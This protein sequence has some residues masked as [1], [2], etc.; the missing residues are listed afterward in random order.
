MAA[1]SEPMQKQP[2]KDSDS[3]GVDTN[4]ITAVV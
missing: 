4:I 3:G 1:V 2:A